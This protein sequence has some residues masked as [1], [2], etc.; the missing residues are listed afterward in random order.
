[1]I[2]TKIYSPLSG[3]ER[4]VIRLWGNQVVYRSPA[5]GPIKQCTVRQ[6]E[7]WLA[8]ED[9]APGEPVDAATWRANA[10]VDRLLFRKYPEMAAV[11]VKDWKPN[12]YVLK[13]LGVMR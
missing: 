10:E 13:L 4:E 6:F 5:S 7:A 3:S 1:M 11:Q 8:K 2:E 9:R 12:P